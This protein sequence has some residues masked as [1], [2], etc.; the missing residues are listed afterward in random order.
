MLIKTDQLKVVKSYTL[1]PSVAPSAFALIGS[2]FSSS[3][4]GV[5]YLNLNFEKAMSIHVAPQYS[6][7]K[8]GFANITVCIRCDRTALYQDQHPVNPCPLCGS[9]VSEYLD[10]SRVGTWV[11]EVKRWMTPEEYENWNTQVIDVPLEA[12]QDD[13]TSEP[14]NSKA[15][16]KYEQGVLLLIG[17][18]V[19]AG[20][21]KLLGG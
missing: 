5:P 17:V 6:A 12:P 3:C 2:H 8:G 10:G 14:E 11:K 20:L 4:R 1:C 13:T 16:F 7:Y 21:S 18:L 15:H 9:K 19:G